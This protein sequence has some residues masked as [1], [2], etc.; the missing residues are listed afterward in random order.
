VGHGFLKNFNI[1]ID[2]ERRRV[3]L[4]N[5]T[6][7]VGNE[8]PGE[9][10]LKAV[11]DNRS[12]KIIVAHVAPDSPA[13]KA[14]VQVGDQLLSVDGKELIGSIGYDELGAMVDGKVG[15]KVT[16]SLSRRGELVRLELERKPLVND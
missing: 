15:T 5:F 6:G 2:Y 1:V 3:W 4:E 16:V 10:G 14:G 12:K 11:Y 13:K 9:T 7:Q 8:P